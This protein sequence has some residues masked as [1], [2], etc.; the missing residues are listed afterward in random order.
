MHHSDRCASFMHSQT[1]S[2]WA[3]QHCISCLH[4]GH[5]LKGCRCCA[6]PICCCSPTCLQMMAPGGQPMFMVRPMGPGQQG[7]PMPM[8][9]SQGPGVW[10]VAGCWSC[11]WLVCSE[12]WR[13]WQWVAGTWSADGHA[14]ACRPDTLASS[15]IPC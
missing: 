12:L 6:D 11:S 1:P 8:Q 9:A 4:H 10:G 2:T 15:C 5:V 13:A 14:A 7:M 3:Q